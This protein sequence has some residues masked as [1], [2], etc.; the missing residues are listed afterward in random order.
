MD[1]LRGHEIAHQEDDFEA[2]GD[3][4]LD[5]PPAIGSDER[6]MQVRAYNYWASLLGERNLPSIE[7]LSPDQLEDFGPYSVLLDFS[8]GIDNPAIVYLGAALREECEIG[9]AIRYINDVPSRSLLSRLT[10][11]YL[12]IIA[13]AA[14]IG[15]EAGFL[16]QRGAEIL[17]RGIL[18]PFSSDDET[19][20]FVFGVINWK[21]VV[22]RDIGEEIDREVEAALRAAP[23]SPPVAPIWADGPAADEFETPLDLAGMESPADDA[24]LEEWLALARDSAEQARTSEARSHTALYRA[25]GLSYDFALVTI[26]RPEQYAEL[27]ADA[28][29]KVQARAPMTA[30]VKLVFGSTYDKTRITE[31]ATALDHAR[32][33]NIELGTFG[34][35]LGRYEGGLKALVRDERAQRR[36]SAPARPDRQQTARSAMKTA[37]ALDP[38][39]IATDGDGLAVVIARRERDGALSIV[40]ALPEGSDLGQRVIVAA[41]T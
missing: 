41:A 27:L 34:D 32:A 14:P 16:N 24:P 11:H 8:T 26:A 22:A 28:G 39:S 17:Y 38:L 10:D 40:G 2:A 9:S 29:M 31:Y 21:Q 13:N 1:S 23:P 7:D 35:Y 25:I 5:T 18:M 36:T 6:R 19:I 3:V 15:F 4:A 20:D 37:A 30:V 12:Q 33:A